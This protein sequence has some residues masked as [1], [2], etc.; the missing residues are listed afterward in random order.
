MAE[1]LVKRHGKASTT[2]HANATIVLVQG[3]HGGKSQYIPWLGF[4]D[5]TSNH[6]D[7]LVAEERRSHGR[8]GG[9]SLETTI[10]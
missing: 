7:E 3:C 4:A 5:E 6:G 8:K 9:L 1:R 10:A 2:A